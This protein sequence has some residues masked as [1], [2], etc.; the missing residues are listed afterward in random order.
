MFS[1]GGRF[2]LGRLSEGSGYCIGIIVESRMGREKSAGRAADRDNGLGHTWIIGEPFFKDVQV[3]FEVC[4]LPFF[5]AIDGALTFWQ[6]KTKR[7]GFQR[8]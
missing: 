5:C 1:P 3:A 6:W 2:G 7:V 8:V 4:F